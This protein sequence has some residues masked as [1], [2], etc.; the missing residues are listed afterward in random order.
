MWQSQKA[1]LDAICELIKL[2]VSQYHKPY[3]MR[4]TK[5]IIT[6]VGDRFKPDDIDVH[7]KRDKSK[8]ERC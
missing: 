8:F 4:H 3:G 2:Y 1:D 5:T 6:L 7:L